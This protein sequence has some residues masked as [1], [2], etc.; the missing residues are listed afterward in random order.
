M[1]RGQDFAKPADRR[2]SS[3]SGS[4]RSG[5]ARSGRK[6]ER[7]EAALPIWVWTVL[8]VAILLLIAAVYHVTRP[9]EPLQFSPSSSARQ[10]QAN[11]VAAA[12]SAD[13]AA[14]L[15]PK[16]ERRTREDADAA[17]VEI[18]ASE[19]P[20]FDFYSMLPSDGVGV[21]AVTESSSKVEARPPE[22]KPSRPV[23]ETFVEPS[24]PAAEAA[25][26]AAA[27]DAAERARQQQQD[28]A[29][30]LKRLAEQ[31][32]RAEQAAQADPSA[33]SRAAAEAK[34]QAEARSKALAAEAAAASKQKAAEAASLATQMRQEEEARKAAKARKA[35]Q[36]AK[37][38]EQAKAQKAAAAEATVAK[39]PA[40]KSTSGRFAVQVAALK[41]VE[42]AERIRANLLM[43][44][45]SAR[46]EQAEVKG[47]TWQR[48]R[49][50]PFASRED[51]QATKQ[52]LAAAGHQA[53]LV[54]LGKP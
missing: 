21:P 35:E 50:G 24:N 49:L 23:E 19:D 4:G 26:L 47:Q 45:F 37:A 16:P 42:D 28:K 52:A 34:A 29:E 40:A 46:I 17:K 33:A 18:P 9:A 3:R 27:A 48:L 36:A 5:S 2:G 39:A 12:G 31:A 14:A 20:T 10:A 11:A 54:P 43:Q 15:D 8:A 13:D 53:A 1:A 38:A 44:G 25:R 30:Q 7:S 6:P 32:A 51:A 41:S 22:P